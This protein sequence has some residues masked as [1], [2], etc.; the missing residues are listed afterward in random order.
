MGAETV[1]TFPTPL[2]QQ[3]V[4]TMVE[5]FQ[6]RL[7]VEAVL[8][9]NSLA[10]GTATPES[11]IDAAVLIA[12]D[13]PATEQ[14]VLEQQWLNFYARHDIF[15]RFKASGRFTAVH[16]DLIDG[17]FNPETWDDG[18]GPD[19]FELEIGNRLVY[20]LPLWEEGSALTDLKSVWLP[21]YN[22]TLQR[23]RLAMV[24][25][26]CT[27]DLEFIPFYIDRGLYFQA[28]DRLYK[29]FREFLQ[30]LFIARRT[31]PLAYNKWI[32]EQVE[33]HLGLPELYPKLP[34]ILEIPQLES[35]V[36]Q[37]KARLLRELLEQWTI[38]E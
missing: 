3:A 19:G 12:S 35:R 29:A 16:L 10:R 9:V 14:Q 23:E 24:R 21:Y 5:F 8:L 38:G 13:L 26:A 27:Y 1:T 22:P 32:R 4:E 36:M 34:Q 20:S 28:F 7:H 17:Q 33:R 31:Y 11:D 37:S 25:A 6:G 2:H 18:G 15:R 30:A